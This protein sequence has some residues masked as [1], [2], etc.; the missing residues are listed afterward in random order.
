MEERETL[1]FLL[2]GSARTWGRTVRPF[3]RGVF[4]GVWVTSDPRARGTG[5]ASEPF[6]ASKTAGRTAGPYTRPQVALATG[7]VAAAT[8]GARALESQL[9]RRRARRAR[10]RRAL[11]WPA[12]GTA[13][14]ERISDK[15][16]PC[17]AR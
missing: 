9:R 8:T 16:R 12:L 7:P 6:R 17:G 4:C 1:V 10:A 11:P 14:A 2:K 3:G 15:G 5:R 13:T